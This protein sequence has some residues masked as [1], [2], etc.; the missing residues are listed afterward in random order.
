MRTLAALAVPVIAEEHGPWAASL[1][2]YLSPL[3]NS[4]CRRNGPRPCFD[5]FI[6]NARPGGLAAGNEDQRPDEDQPELNAGVGLGVMLRRMVGMILGM[7]GVASSNVSMMPGGFVVTTLVMLC[8]LGV[9]L[10]CLFVVF[11][12]FLVVV[13]SLMVRHVNLHFPSCWWT[14]H[15]RLLMERARGGPPSVRRDSSENL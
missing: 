4:R 5:R 10:G 8:S 6:Q 11:G 1:R 2:P 12:G 9:M 15:R 14:C 3:G 7:S 13:R